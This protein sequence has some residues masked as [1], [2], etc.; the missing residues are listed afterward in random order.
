[1]DKLLSDQRIWVFLGSV[2]LAL[3]GWGEGFKSWSEMFQIHS[4]LSLF[5]VMGGLFAANA[6]HNVWQ[7]PPTIVET[8]APKSTVTTIT[9]TPPEVK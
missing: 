3:A 6:A 9:T 1:M 8:T 2:L 4:V 7:T 5:G